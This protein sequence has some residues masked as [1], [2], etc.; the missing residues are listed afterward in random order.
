MDTVL[1][2]PRRAWWAAL[3]LAL[4][5]PA[6]DP[7][8]PP[9]DPPPP[10]K[11]APAAPAAPKAATQRGELGKN[12]VLETL[13]DGHRRVLV[14]A[15]VCFRE[16]PL[17]MFLCRT[18]TKEHESVVHAD[19]DARHVHA[20]LLAAGAKAGGP[21]Q[22]EPKY[23]PARGSVIKVTVEYTRDGKT[24]TVPAQEWVRDAKTRKALPYDWVFAGSVLFPNP[25]DPK[26]PPLY[27]AN[28]GDVICVSNFPDAMLD[29]P[30]N[31]PQEDAERQYE[32]FTEHIPPLGTKVT[33]IL[34]PAKESDPGTNGDKK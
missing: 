20:G 30:V 12:V 7:P 17:E 1:L 32:A 25:D 3:G 34:E 2:R 18:N 21:V 16:G 33:V 5:V 9:Y 8:A 10:A 27:A 11:P 22:F 31:S 28:G 13:P 4:L 15:E 23:Q 26:K 6:C 24:V 29:L 19:I 14:Q